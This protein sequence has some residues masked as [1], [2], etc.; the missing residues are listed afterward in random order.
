MEFVSFFSGV[1]LIGNSVTLKWNWCTHPVYNII[2]ELNR[3]WYEN[4]CLMRLPIN[5]DHENWTGLVQRCFYSNHSTGILCRTHRFT[6]K[7][8]IVTTSTYHIQCYAEIYAFLFTMFD[9]GDGGRFSACISRFVI[10]QELMARRNWYTHTHTH[11][12]SHTFN[13]KYCIIFDL[14]LSLHIIINDQEISII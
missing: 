3:V 4:N 9:F 8:F 7:L 6:L 13:T 11:R 2:V 1:V 14:H 5:H 12:H 10:L